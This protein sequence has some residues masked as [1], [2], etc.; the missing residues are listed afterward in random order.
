MN[1]L[2]LINNKRKKVCMKNFLFS[3]IVVS[4]YA[5]CTK[6]ESLSVVKNSD[7]KELSC[8]QTAQPKSLQFLEQQYRCT[9]Q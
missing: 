7:S 2:V 1:M 4:L 3:F 9:R 6:L 5:G 8:T